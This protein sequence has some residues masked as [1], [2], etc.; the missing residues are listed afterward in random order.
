MMPLIRE[1]LKPETL[2]FLIPITAII[3]VY[4]LKAVKLMTEKSAA[5]KKHVRL[6][7]EDTNTLLRM[8]AML[9]RMESR[10]E[11]LETILMERSSGTVHSI[12]KRHE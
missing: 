1:L 10:I 8:T 6:S 7:S 4:G 12:P 11:A 3:C 5:A 2:I 9:D